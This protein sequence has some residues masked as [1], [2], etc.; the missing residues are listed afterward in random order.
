MRYGISRW[1]LSTLTKTPFEAVD[2]A[3]KLGFTSIDYETHFLDVGLENMMNDELLEEYYTK[4]YLHAKSQGVI[5]FQTHA[6]YTS[7]PNYILDDYWKKIIQSI[8]VTSYLHCPYMI[9]H[10]QVFPLNKEVNFDEKEMQF[11]IEFYTRLIPYLEKYN[12]TLCLENIYDWDHKKIRQIY[13]SYPEHL[14]EYVD[15]LNSSRIGIC[16]DTGHMN[17]ATHDVKSC[18]K[19]FGD[20]LYALHLHDNYGELDDHFRIHD[21]TI[22][23]DGLFKELHDINYQ[24][25]F[26]LEIKPIK[27]EV[28]Y[29]QKAHDDLVELVEK[30]YD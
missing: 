27:N 26:N 20:K 15:R 23:W 8:K 19:I 25:V 21:G 28:E 10:P 9:M 16:L 1:G 5:F 3:K 13:V 18:V 22:D 17:L 29:Y 12:V 14:R 2:L 4:L 11:N 7:F 30:Y 6:S 24:G